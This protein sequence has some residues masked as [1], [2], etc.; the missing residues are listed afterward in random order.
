VPGFRFRFPPFQS[1][2]VGVG[3]LGEQEQSVTLMERP[4]ATRSESEG[5]HS[6][7]KRLQFR[8]KSLP[9]P[10][11]IPSCE[12]W[13]FSDHNAWAKCLNNADEL[14]AEARLLHVTCCPCTAIL[15]ARVA[16]T[17]NVYI[18]FAAK[19]WREGSNVVPLRNRRPMLPQYLP[20]VR[21][22]LDLEFA[23]KAGTLE[24]KIEAADSRE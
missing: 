8:S 13:V 22:N 10:G 17:Q 14:T 12:T 5:Q 6:V 3:K 19:V 4:K 2:A 21:I 1:L 16:A 24:A 23:A 18:P 9:R 11:S 15:L 7:T 20:A